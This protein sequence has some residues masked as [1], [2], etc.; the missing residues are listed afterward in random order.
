MTHE[1]LVRD[2]EWCSV[3]SR[4]WGGRKPLNEMYSECI[5]LGNEGVLFRV[6]GME[7]QPA[8]PNSVNILAIDPDGET[9]RDLSQVSGDS[10]G[11]KIGRL[12][13]PG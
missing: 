12:I 4:M 11:F 6:R 7:R 5:G 1:E 8:G 9:L 13:P 3:E 2:W 10:K